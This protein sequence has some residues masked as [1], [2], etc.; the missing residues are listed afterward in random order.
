M[1]CHFRIMHWANLQLSDQLIHAFALRPELGIDVGNSA[2]KYFAKFH[3]LVKY[4]GRIAEH[5]TE[6]NTWNN[7]LHIKE[8]KS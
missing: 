4:A 5:K 2:L 3:K 6:E 8:E 7:K 1:I